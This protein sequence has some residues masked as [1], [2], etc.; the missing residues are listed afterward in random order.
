MPTIGGVLSKRNNCAFSYLEIQLLRFVAVSDYA[1]FACEGMKDSMQE[2]TVLPFNIHNKPAARLQSLNRTGCP[3][4]RQSREQMDFIGVA[5]QKHL[6]YSCRT[7]EITI[8]LE[9]PAR[10]ASI[11]QVW[12][13]VAADQSV[14]IEIRLQRIAQPRKETCFPCIAP[15]DIP[16][17]PAAVQRFPCRGKQFCVL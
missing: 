12:K 1:W 9:T 11:H 6:G 17:E 10:P 14:N 4:L 3:F 7:A 8:D 16:P 15:P 5:L 2:F 13:C